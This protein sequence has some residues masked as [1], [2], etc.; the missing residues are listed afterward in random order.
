M[1][2]RNEMV[3]KLEN[4]RPCVK[5]SSLPKGFDQVHVHTFSSPMV[6][7][8]ANSKAHAKRFDWMQPELGAPIGI[9]DART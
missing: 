2:Y 1:Q 5:S 8:K 4:F 9:R 3:F 6:Y 7:L